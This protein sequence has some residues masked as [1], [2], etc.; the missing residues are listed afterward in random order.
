MTIRSGDQRG[1]VLVV[2]LRAEVLALVKARLETDVVVRDLAVLP[3]EE[4]EAATGRPAVAA[5]SLEPDAPGALRAI[6]RLSGLGTR[7]VAL[8]STKDADAILKAMRAGASEFALLGDAAAIAA[9]VRAELRPAAGSPGGTVVTVFAAKG[10]VG[11]T[12][13]AVNLAAALQRRGRTCIVDLDLDLGDVLAFLDVTGSYSIRDVITNLRRLDREL[14]DTS[15]P[16]HRCGLHVLSQSHKLEE[17]PLDSATV[18]E[19]LAFL[20]GQY[21]WVVV[22][23]ARSFDE[24]PLAALDASDRILLV[25]T[26]DVPAVR[27]ARRCVEVFRR[28]GYGDGRVQLVLNRHQPRARVPDDAIAETAGLPIAARLCN[29]FAAAAEAIHRGQLVAESTPRS[30]LLR[31]LEALGPLVGV[32]ATTER[33]E[34]SILKR[35]FSSRTVPHGAQ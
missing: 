1:A 24:V 33:E 13:I 10:G 6:A 26:Q 21:D 23:G 8:A 30:P 12:T 14:L 28:L 29:D 31:D 15:L 7:V 27:N 5:I 9:A 18:G 16:R 2:G 4:G 17:E 19:L 34:P 22:D 3:P 20:R 35:F 25:A 32:E 11:A